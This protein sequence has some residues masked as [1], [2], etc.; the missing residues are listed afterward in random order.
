M[1]S[2][3]REGTGRFCSRTCAGK[4][5]MGEN[6]PR[7][8]GGRLVDKEGYVRIRQP[9]H[10][11]SDA[12]GYVLES[13]LR[14][15]EAIGRFLMPQEVVHHINEQPGDNQIENLK[16]YA[17][18]AEHMAE[19]AVERRRDAAGRL[20]GKDDVMVEDQ[21]EGD[22]WVM[23]CGD[24]V[25]VLKGL[26]DDSVGLSVFSPPFVAMY[27]YTDSA[28][29]LGNSTDLAR[30]F[31]HYSFVAAELLRV[32]MPGRTV[33]VHLAQAQT[34]KREGQEIGL[35]DFRGSMIR[36][37]QEMGF[38]YYGEVCIDKDPQVKAIRTKDRGLLFK[39]LAK[40]SAN[41]RMAQADYLLQFRKP[42]ENPQPIAAG[43]SERYGNEDGWITP[44]EWI[45]W[46]APV[47]YRAG[48]DYP[49]GIR[50]TDVLNVS[51]ARDERDE[52]HLCPLQL[53]VIERAIKLWSAPGDLI[54]SP[55]AGVGSE[56][57]VAVGLGRRFCGIE[58][59]RSYFETACANVERATQTREQTAL[60]I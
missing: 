46:A 7:W 20:A 22:G 38:T 32:M 10:P 9:E 24:S 42:G 43:I 11:R 2:A 57:Y 31:D 36:C 51:A 58:L 53:G 29:D 21:A 33:A 27:V 23:Y 14:M 1:P 56:G 6:H 54:L 60:A 17:S 26:P 52:R 30:F 40:D 45:E 55:F 50:E 18:Q 47:W 19:H 48:P 15:E 41:M 35:L 28:H 8:N 25:D 49:G 3:Q 12:R 5:R 37:M 34:R 4:W 16:L 59:K 44:E 39:T 13:R